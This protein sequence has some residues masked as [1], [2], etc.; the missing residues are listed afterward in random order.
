MRNQVFIEEG[1]SIPETIETDNLAYDYFGFPKHP[2]ILI[3]EGHSD[4]EC[5]ERDFIII[6]IKIWNLR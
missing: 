6:R 4:K 2:K 1:S 5:I 3:V